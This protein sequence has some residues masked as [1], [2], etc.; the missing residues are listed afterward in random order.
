MIKLS[1]IWSK[2]IVPLVTIGILLLI[3]YPV[4]VE[5][6]SGNWFL[7]WILVGCPFGIGKM[8]VWLI[9]KNFGIAGM[10]GIIAFNFIIGGLIGGVIA[11][12]K[13]IGAFIYLVQIV[14]RAIQRGHF[15]TTCPKVE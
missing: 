7:L 12:V 11:M 6:G 9:P 2:T 10:V 5:N 4:C 8:F 15:R 13:L 14:H 3:F 1:G